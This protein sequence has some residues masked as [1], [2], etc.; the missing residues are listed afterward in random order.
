MDPKWNQQGDGP[1]P[2][3]D[4]AELETKLKLSNK[5]FLQVYVRANACGSCAEPFALIT[6]HKTS[7]RHAHTHARAGARL[8]YPTALSIPSA[9]APPQDVQELL[10]SEGWQDLATLLRQNSGHVAGEEK[11]KFGKM[12]AQ[13]SRHFNALKER[14]SAL[15]DG[16]TN[17]RGRSEPAPAA[18]LA[19][20]QVLSTFHRAAPLWVLG[21]DTGEEGLAQ[22]EIW[23][24]ELE[25]RLMKGFISQV[26]GWET[27]GSKGSG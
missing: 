6:S 16:I 17:S 3:D 15:I 21:H 2:Y 13:V 19:V 26:R 23:S 9:R 24:N 18:I 5:D 20:A 27:G 4:V 8:S 12:V 14:G 1:T 25:S 11:V 7:S 22:M 10:A